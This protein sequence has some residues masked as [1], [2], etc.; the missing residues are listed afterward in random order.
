MSLIT[1][2]CANLPLLVVGRQAMG[3]HGWNLWSLVGAGPAGDKAKALQLAVHL[4]VTISAA[5]AAREGASPDDAGRDYL[6]ALIRQGL[7]SSDAC[8]AV[9]YTSRLKERPAPTLTG[10]LGLWREVRDAFTHALRQQRAGLQ[11]GMTLLSLPQPEPVAI[12]SVHRILAPSRCYQDGVDA[13]PARVLLLAPVIASAMRPSLQLLE[14][15]Y[16]IPEDIRITP[17]PSASSAFR[18]A[19][20]AI[21]PAG[22]IVHPLEPPSAVDLPVPPAPVQAAPGSSPAVAGGKRKRDEL[23]SLRYS[24]S[25]LL[26][27]ALDRHTCNPLKPTYAA[28]A[29][30]IRL[31]PRTPSVARAFNGSAGTGHPFSVSVAQLTKFCRTCH[32]KHFGGQALHVVCQRMREVLKDHARK[33]IQ[34]D[35]CNKASVRRSK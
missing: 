19:A 11:M 25:F 21:P 18:A 3:D 30:P 23:N 14:G 16:V 24:S 2:W 15:Q 7:A 20:A 34:V 31:P 28:S 27:G 29:R 10:A 17:Q 9:L 4:I 26:A 32:V 5:A 33:R 1:L 35:A 6:D 8:S 12:A 13:P 22:P